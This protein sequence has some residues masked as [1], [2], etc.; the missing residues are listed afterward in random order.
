MSDTYF[1][2]RASY[3]TPTAQFGLLLSGGKVSLVFFI[4]LFF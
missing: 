4:V 2:H 1:L 3:A